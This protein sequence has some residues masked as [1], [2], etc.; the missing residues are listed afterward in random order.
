MAWLV[1][2]KVDAYC[3]RKILDAM[4]IH[5]DRYKEIVIRCLWS[6]RI[7]GGG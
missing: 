2:S 6:G 4:I 1:Q 5:T 3:Q 7:E